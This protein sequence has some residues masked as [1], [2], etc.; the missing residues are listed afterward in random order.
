[1]L[2]CPVASEAGQAASAQQKPTAAPSAA[3]AFNSAGIGTGSRVIDGL[4]QFHLGDDLRWAQAGFD[5]SKWEQLPADRPWGDAGHRGYTGF[6]WYRRQVALN[7]ADKNPLAL[8]LPELFCV[9]DVYWNG[10]KVGGIGT[11]PPHPFWYFMPRPVAVPLPSAPGASSGTLAIRLW[12]PVLGAA[13]VPDLGGFQE[14][15]Q[16]GYAPLIQQ[17]QER[18]VEH[19]LRVYAIRY[20]LW[21][22]VFCAGLIA[23]ILWLRSPSQWILLCVGA[24]LIPFVIALFVE[25]LFLSFSMK[26]AMA[27]DWL[28]ECVQDTAFLFLILLLAGLPNRPGVRGFRFWKWVCL[29]ASAVSLF[30]TI[31]VELAVLLMPEPHPAFYSFLRRS[32]NILSGTNLLFLP[33]VL[34]GCLVFGKRRLSS[35]LFMAAVALDQYL[36]IVSGI[37]GAYF[38]HLHSMLRFLHGT[39]FDLGGSTVKATTISTFLLLLAIIYAVWDQLSRELAQQRRVNAELKAA[40]EVQTL[41]V[42][43]EERGA[44]GYAVASVY[45]PASEVG[46]DFFQV[47]PLEGDGTLI[48][49]G[50]VSGKGLRAAMTVSLIVGAVRTLAERDSNPAAVLAGLNR[51]LIGRTQGGFATCCAVRIDPTGQAS[52]ANAGHCQPYLDG[53]EVELPAGLPLGLVDGIAYDEIALAIAHGQQ[54]TLVSDGVV[55]ARNHQGELYGFER[56][57]QLMQNRPT[58]EQLARTAIDFGQDD[59]ITVLTVTRLAAEPAAAMQLSDLSPA[60]A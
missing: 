30:K 46:G 58:A 3:G 9:A 29:A 60:P 14:A 24:Y 13:T 19:N 44:H 54:L 27:V 5:D 25:L 53:R 47:I 51:R 26:F 55:E 12:A 33:L 35:L 57:S 17:M 43:A 20:A 28:T 38:P 32:L 31:L 42:A 40:Q 56:L 37:I 36:G 10:V 39:L 15:P 48:V 34:L 11:P 2:L 50:D 8:Y 21:V 45:R 16:L 23:L 4:W 18:W 22:V 1:L 59:D 49:A 52:M 6:A 41:L 7:P